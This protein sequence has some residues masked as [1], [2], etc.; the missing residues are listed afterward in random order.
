MISLVL[1]VIAAIHQIHRKEL[2][3]DYYTGQAKCGHCGHVF[4]VVAYREGH[5]ITCDRC[6]VKYEKDK[7]GRWYH[8]S[9]FELTL[10]K[11]DLIL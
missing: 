9:D 1:E 10:L 8:V 5:T 2:T 6:R 7:E 3:M 11:M 4:N